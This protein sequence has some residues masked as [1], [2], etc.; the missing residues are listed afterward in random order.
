M[1]SDEEVKIMNHPKSEKAKKEETEKTGKKKQ[2]DGD[3]EDDL[4]K[5]I[6]RLS[7]KPVLTKKAKSDSVKSDATSKK[8]NVSTAKPKGLYICY[9]KQI[10]YPHKC[11]LIM[12]NYH[13]QLFRR[14]KG[15]ILQNM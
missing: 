2:S 9:F 6:K 1:S 8:V 7:R 11:M 15:E 12:C 13:R 14:E 3:T 5:D 10:F 4:D